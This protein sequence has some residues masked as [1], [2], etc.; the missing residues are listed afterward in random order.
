MN[1]SEEYN[2]DEESPS[3]L[4]FIFI[5]KA[6]NEMLQSPKISQEIG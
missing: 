2:S 6:L 1:T 3:M 4:F 5:G